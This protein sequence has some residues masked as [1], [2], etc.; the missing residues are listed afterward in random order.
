MIGK[1]HGAVID[2]SDPKRLS[3]FYAE[4][5]GFTIV[6]SEDDWC[7][8]GDAEDRPGIAFQRVANYVAPVWPTGE[9]PT[10]MHIDI[11]IEDFDAAVAEIE[12]L[13][14]KLLSNSSTIFWVCQDPEGHPFCIFKPH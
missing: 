4:L 12:S 2:C 13:G 11:R 9:V 14:G 6:Q 5:L 7:V 8:I 1:W 3:A 10:Q